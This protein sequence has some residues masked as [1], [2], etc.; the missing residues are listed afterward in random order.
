LAERGSLYHGHE[1]V[2]RMINSRS[3]H[4]QA[5]FRMTERLAKSPQAG[6]SFNVVNH[7]S[8][9]EGPKLYAFSASAVAALAKRSCGNISSWPT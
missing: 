2:R 8:N 7:T 3:G 5:L 1:T 9:L 4:S 6:P